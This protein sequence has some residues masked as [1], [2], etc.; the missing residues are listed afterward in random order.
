MIVH[1][2]DWCLKDI[3]DIGAMRT[4]KLKQNIDRKDAAECE[5]VYHFCNEQCEAEKSGDGQ[6]FAG[7]TR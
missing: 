4:D 7:L 1:R 2:C 3:G 6:M 5:R